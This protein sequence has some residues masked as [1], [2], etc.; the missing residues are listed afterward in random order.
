MMDM[1]NKPS[2]AEKPVE[3]PKKVGTIKAFKIDGSQDKKEKT[4][5]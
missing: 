5:E 1:F 2:Q 3:I 4:N